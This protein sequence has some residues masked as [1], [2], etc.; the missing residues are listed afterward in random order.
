MTYLIDDLA[1]AGIVE[2]RLNPADRRQRKIVAT[3]HGLGAPPD[4]AVPKSVW[5]AIGD[6]MPHRCVQFA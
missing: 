2:R 1:T 5:K 3:R 6:G 4:R